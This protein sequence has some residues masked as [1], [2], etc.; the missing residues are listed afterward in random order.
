VNFVHRIHLDAKGGRRLWKQVLSL[1]Q[2]ADAGL[3][4]LVLPPEVK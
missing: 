4:G 2:Q 3:D 1:A